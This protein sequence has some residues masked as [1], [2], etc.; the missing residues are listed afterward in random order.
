MAERV[1][2]YVEVNSKSIRREKVEDREFIVIPSYTLK[3]NSVM[4]GGFYP[5]DEID[6]HYKSLENTLAPLG[7][8]TVNGKHVSAF[9]PIAIN[10]NHI[11]AFNRNVKKVGDRIYVEKWVDVLKANESD[12][13]K[14]LVERV[15]AIER[16]ESTDPIHSS[17]AVFLD[18]EPAVNNSEYNW[19]AKFK[20]IDHDAILLD[21]VGA[22]TP[23]DGV[24]LMVNSAD[25]K[26]LAAN[27]GVLGGDTY[28]N[29]EERL[30]AAARERFVADKERD[31]VWIADFDDQQAIVVQNGGNANVY[32]YKMEAG[33]IIFED[34]GT[35]VQRRETW[36]AKI[37]VVNKALEA[38]SKMFNPSQARLDVNDQEG[39]MPL[40]PEE[41]AELMKGFSDIVA[42]AIKPVSDGLAE[43]TKTVGTIQTNHDKLAETLTANSR[44]E[45]ADMRAVVGK[46]LGDL[47]ANS[48]SGEALAEAYK[49]CRSAT[50][51]GSGNLDVNSQ[52]GAPDPSKHFAEE[53]K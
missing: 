11:G 1:N 35:P 47:V 2:I 51:I 32:G 43:V 22:N 36:V 33:K 3:A 6:A 15:E 46:K 10:K 53:P 52:E 45:E 41:K 25:A 37:P 50:P 42:N 5:A 49:Q 34:T 48:L 12:Q 23:E 28:R 31:Y 38:I 20:Q 13:G 29:K 18:R 19:V 24:G 26:P 17:I 21:E 8:P 30:Q 44:K 27:S 40:T 9:D 7:H 16:G 14:R 39:E 4:N